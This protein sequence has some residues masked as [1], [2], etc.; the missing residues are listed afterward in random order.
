LA[1]FNTD[2]HNK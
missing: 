2:W 1:R